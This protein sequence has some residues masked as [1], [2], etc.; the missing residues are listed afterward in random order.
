MMPPLQ[1]EAGDIVIHKGVGV[2]GAGYSGFEETF[3]ERELREKGI[4]HVGVAGIAV[5]YCV[6]ATGLDA[7]RARFETT[8]LENLIR[9]VR[10]KD[11]PGVLADLRAAGMKVAGSEDWM[12]GVLKK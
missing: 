10:E 4:T 2:E 3:L 12:V 1:A 7:H 5:E 8:V 11:V 9:A 6:R